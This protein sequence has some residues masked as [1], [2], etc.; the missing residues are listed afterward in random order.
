MYAALSQEWVLECAG[1]DCFTGSYFE[2]SE[3]T[4]HGR[5][6]GATASRQRSCRMDQ[7]LVFRKQKKWVQPRKLVTTNTAQPNAVKSTQPQRS[8]QDWTRSRPAGLAKA[9]LQFSRASK[10]TSKTCT[11]KPQSLHLHATQ[12]KAKKPV[13]ARELIIPE[14][15]AWSQHRS[16]SRSEVH[17]AAPATLGTPELR[18]TSISSV[19]G[20]LSRRGSEAKGDRGSFESRTVSACP[21]GRAGSTLSRKRPRQ[22]QISPSGLNPVDRYCPGP[23]G[24]TY[25]PLL[26]Q[27]ER[28]R[29]GRQSCSSDGEVMSQ[30]NFSLGRKVASCKSSSVPRKQDEVKPS[31]RELGVNNSPGSSTLAPTMVS[32]AQAEQDQAAPFLKKFTRLDAGAD[33]KVD[34]HMSPGAKIAQTKHDQAA[35]PEEDVQRM[36]VVADRKTGSRMSIRVVP[37]ESSECRLA[38]PQPPASARLRPSTI[39]STMTG[40]LSSRMRPGSAIVSAKI[41]EATDVSQVPS[42][43]DFAVQSTV[44]SAQEGPKPSPTASHGSQSPEGDGYTPP[45]KRFV[46]EHWRVFQ[47]SAGNKSGVTGRGRGGARRGGFAAGRGRRGRG[48][49]KTLV[50]PNPNPVTGGWRKKQGDQR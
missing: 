36:D 23:P 21:S 22:E 49:Q 29:E 18:A 4:P 19:M 1:G 9:T 10:S 25:P 3:V 5:Q 17:D 31:E 44:A 47:G 32:I 34:Y 42:T 27:L 37:R 30:Q 12:E 41:N 40:E 35:S 26:R 16:V 33:C 43:I 48:T 14:T 46:R 6:R 45:E 7:R 20:N 2:S 8:I 13:R 38:P 50:A 11:G 24:R 15:P 28:T 39:T